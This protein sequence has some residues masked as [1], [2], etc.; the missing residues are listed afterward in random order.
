LIYNF[1]DADWDDPMLAWDFL[2]G[3]LVFRLEA[4]GDLMSVAEN[5]G[6]RQ[7]RDV[8]SQALALSPS[9]ARSVRARLEALNTDE[10]RD[11]A[12]DYVRSICTTKARDIIDDAVGG[13]I[14]E[15][16]SAQSDG[17]TIR[18][19]QRLAFNGKPL[20]GLGA[21][22]LLGKENDVVLSRYDALFVPERMRTYLQQVQVESPAGL[23]PLAARPVQ[24]AGRQQDTRGEGA[25]WGSWYFALALIGWFAWRARA[26]RA[27]LALSGLGAFALWPSLLFAAMGCAL[28]GL[29]L[30]SH[31]TGFQNNPL[32][33]VFVPLDLMLV[34]AC[35]RFKRGQRAWLTPVLRYAVLRGL[36]AA[37]VLLLNISADGTTPLALPL[38][39]LTFFGLLSWLARRCAAVQ[40]A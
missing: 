33:L 36:M 20:A 31:E 15:Q 30:L 16:L 5:Y 34:P 2:V 13:A 28:W 19:H 21:D 35:I 17:M 29:Q 22:L 27:R 12:H 3:Q 32:A 37:A 40:R 11:Y 1:G 4:A 8:F 18:E 24:I 38:L 39:A 6:V 14:H 9:Q 26:L 25:T 23:V 7:N 10:N